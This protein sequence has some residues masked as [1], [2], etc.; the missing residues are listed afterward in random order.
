MGNFPAVIDAKIV[1]NLDNSVIVSSNVV[2]INV[3]VKYQKTI[4]L[5]L[6]D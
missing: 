6:P 5:Q 4:R 3:I 2:K 1:H